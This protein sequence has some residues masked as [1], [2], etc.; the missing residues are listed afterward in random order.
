MIKCST[1]S[2]VEKAQLIHGALY[3]YSKTNY[4]G[5]FIKVLIVCK[6]HGE[7]FQ[8]PGNHL[9]GKGCKLCKNEKL[10]KDRSFSVKEFIRR[11]SLIHKKYDYKL[12]NY[13]NAHTKIKIICPL[14]EVFE[15]TPMHHL[16]GQGCPKC[17]LIKL[18]KKFS[19]DGDA[20]IEKAKKIHGNKYNYIYVDYK[21]ARTKVKIFCSTHNIFEQTPNK[22]LKGQG[23]PHCA[24]SLGELK[25]R[26]FLEDMEIPFIS[27]KNFFDCYDKRPLPFDFFLPTF[28]IA[29]EYDGLHHFLPVNFT[30]KRSK[31]YLQWNL[32]QIKKRDQIK[33]DYCRMKGINLIRI[34]Y[35][36]FNEIT[37]ILTK[38]NLN[39]RGFQNGSVHTN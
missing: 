33:T 22:H 5:R 31:E 9:C 3:D 38:L 30:G 8:T 4:K 24:S 28:N 21:N 6:K 1:N 13:I 10:S 17:R 15:Q 11:A 14:H 20:F 2:F 26:K 7:F 29:I 23:C 16:K 36:Q 25:I 18:S 35:K 39:E 27:K 12:V 32:D 19:S 34:T 37:A